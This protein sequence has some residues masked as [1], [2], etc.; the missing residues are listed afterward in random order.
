MASA[1]CQWAQHMR[2]LRTAMGL[3]LQK[4]LALVIRQVQGDKA[5]KPFTAPPWY[6]KDGH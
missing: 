3:Y 6:T 4:N 2:R 5:R 1:V